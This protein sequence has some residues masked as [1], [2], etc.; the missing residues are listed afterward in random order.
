[1]ETLVNFMWKHIDDAVPLPHLTL[2]FITI[3]P[4]RN[5]AYNYLI[6]TLLCGLLCLFSLTKIMGKDYPMLNCD[7]LYNISTETGLTQCDYV[8]FDSI[9][10]LIPTNNDLSIMQLNIRGLLNKQDRLNEIINECQADA[11]LLC[12][13]WLKKQRECLVKAPSL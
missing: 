11:I 3:T 5:P 1:M 10:E 7:E 4:N 9:N 8:D 2:V 6:I 13:T 12:E